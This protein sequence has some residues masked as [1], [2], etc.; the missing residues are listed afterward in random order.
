M[1]L[2]TGGGVDGGNPAGMTAGEGLLGKAK[3]C[4]FGMLLGDNEVK[5]AV[6][7]RTGA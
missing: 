3:G 7:V 1:L 6:N 4:V 5:G 2:L